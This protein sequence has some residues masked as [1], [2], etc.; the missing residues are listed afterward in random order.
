M[1]KSLKL[2]GLAS[3]AVCMLS[4]SAQAATTYAGNGNT[5]F[6]GPAGNGMLTF[7]DDGTTLTGTITPGANNGAGVAGQFYDEAVIYFDTQAGGF[8]NTSTL[9]AAPFVDSNGTSNPDILQQAAAGVASNGFGTQRATVNFATGF[10]ADYVLA[11]SPTNTGNGALYSLNTN[12]TLNFISTETFLQTTTSAGPKTFSLS[13]ANIGSP[14]SFQ[15]ATTYLSTHTQ[16]TNMG[17]PSGSIIFRSN[18]T[19]GN[20]LSDVT[21]PT[22]TNN[23]GNDTALL[24]VNTYNTSLVPEPSTWAMMLG[25]FATLALLQHRR[26]HA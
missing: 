17:V 18:E 8:N 2:I 3:T 21:T 16:M 23:P 14:T 11:L 26:R 12:G 15:F 24:G 4:V 20:S 9:I 25:G 5:G 19:F 1:K 6:G 10:G 7:S 13:L 22:Q